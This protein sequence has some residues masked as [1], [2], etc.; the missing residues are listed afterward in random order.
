[1]SAPAAASDD[2]ELKPR[3]QPA[4]VVGVARHDPMAALPGHDDNTRVH[5]VRRARDRAQVPCDARSRCVQRDYLAVPGAQELRES[6]L[7]PPVA[8]DLCDNR[9]R[10]CSRRPTDAGSPEQG[11]QLT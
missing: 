2:D 7:S 10:H 6:G 3:I 8:P 1:M 5:H 11:R 9:G 4:Q